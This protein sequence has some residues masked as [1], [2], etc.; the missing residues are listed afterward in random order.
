MIIKYLKFRIN[1]I[2][3]EFTKLTLLTIFFV[4]VLRSSND[5]NEMDNED[6]DEEGLNKWDGV[7]IEE[8]KVSY[9]IK[10]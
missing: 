7:E 1:L 9:F 6:D 5:K 8:D 4:A 10:F 2:K 3:F